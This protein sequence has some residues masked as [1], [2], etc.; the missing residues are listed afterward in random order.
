ERRDDP[1]SP[2]D[3]ENITSFGFGGGDLWNR[4]QRGFHELRRAE[5]LVDVLHVGLVLVERDLPIELLQRKIVRRVEEPVGSAALP[6]LASLA[7]P[8]VLR[9]LHRGVR[10]FRRL[11]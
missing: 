9:A 8:L 6:P 10:F 2:H 4:R 7:G 11:R 5:R 1:E 3:R